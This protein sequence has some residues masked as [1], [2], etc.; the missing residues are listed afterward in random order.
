MKLKVNKSRAFR[1]C[2]RKTDAQRALDSREAIIPKSSI[3]GLMSQQAQ[4]WAKLRL[5]SA[6]KGPSFAQVL[7]YLDLSQQGEKAQSCE[8]LRA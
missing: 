6:G 8:D 3:R 7:F 2:G 1:M 4:L 5:P